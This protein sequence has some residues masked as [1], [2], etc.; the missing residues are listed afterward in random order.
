VPYLVYYCVSFSFVVIGVSIKPL[1]CNKTVV[2]ITMEMI[3]TAS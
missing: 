1:L 2:K 3:V